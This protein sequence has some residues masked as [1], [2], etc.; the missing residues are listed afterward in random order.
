MTKI[1]TLFAAR[2][3]ATAAADAAKASH[4]ATTRGTP[5]AETASK[6]FTA[7]ARALRVATENHENEIAK[8]CKNDSA[9]DKACREAFVAV[10][11]ALA[12]LA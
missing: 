6:A 10:R 11:E 7:A 8:S 12:A 9:F 1:E 4:A 3:A 5:D 2:V